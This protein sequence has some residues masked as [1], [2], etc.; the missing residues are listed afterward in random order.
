MAG[1]LEYSCQRRGRGSNDVTA[2]GRGSV[3]GQRTRRCSYH[4]WRY[5]TKV[6]SRFKIISLNCRL[7]SIVSS[8]NTRASNLHPY[9]ST[10]HSSS[11]TM[12]NDQNKGVTGA[13]KTVVNFGS[14]SVFPSL[15]CLVSFFYSKSD[16]ETDRN[17]R[18]HSLWREQ[19]PGWCRR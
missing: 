7:T 19:H 16:S 5:K 17:S 11:I 3:E 12:N 10:Q 15:L 4:F 6:S 9:P 14:F 18:Q 13:A 2:Q 1:I 8:N